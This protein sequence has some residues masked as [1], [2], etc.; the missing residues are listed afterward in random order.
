MIGSFVQQP[1]FNTDQFEFKWQQGL[2][3]TMREPKPVMRSNTNTM[4]ILVHGHVRIKFMD[5]SQEHHMTHTGD[6]VQ[7][8]PDE[9]HEF[10]FLQDTL[11]ITLR[12]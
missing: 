5:T 8:T 12:W 7:W 4:A 6:Y 11:V 10:E 3:G 1:Q 9:P 2:K